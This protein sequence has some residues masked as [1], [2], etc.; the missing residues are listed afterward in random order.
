MS[1]RKPW[2]TSTQSNLLSLKPYSKM[3]NF[4]LLWALKLSFASNL[5]CFR[6]ELNFPLAFQS[7]NLPNKISSKHPVSL[8]NFQFQAYKSWLDVKVG[9]WNIF[10]F[11][12]AQF[13]SSVKCKLCAKM[14]HTL[15][16]L[17][18]IIESLLSLKREKASFRQQSWGEGPNEPW[19]S[20]LLQPS[21]LFF[22]RQKSTRQKAK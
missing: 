18:R 22:S 6:F 7:T 8:S 20:A 19:I 14:M 10:R 21:S 5:S 16:L 17:Y 3:V 2:W 13:Y 15:L 1:V 11:T 4:S 12:R 9:L